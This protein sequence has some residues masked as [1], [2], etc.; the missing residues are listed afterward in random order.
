MRG[1]PEVLDAIGWTVKW[2]WKVLLPVALRLRFRAPQGIRVQPDAVEWIK[3]DPW[4]NHPIPTRIAIFHFLP[5]P[6]GNK[7]WLMRRD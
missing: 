5:W 2:R 1:Q 7:F 3:N 6:S 4:L